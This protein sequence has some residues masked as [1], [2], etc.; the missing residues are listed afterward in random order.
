M[1]SGRLRW[2]TRIL[3]DTALI[4]LGYWLA[5]LLRFHGHLPAVNFAAFEHVLPY[6][7][8]L[9]MFV[10][11]VYEPYLYGWQPFGDIFVTILLAVTLLN[12]GTMALTFWSRGFA[13]PR[14]VFLIAP[15]LQVAL[16]CLWRWL[17]RTLTVSSEGV[18]KLVVIGEENPVQFAAR[19]QESSDRPM[20]I[21]GAFRDGHDL[22]QIKEALS[23]ADLVF[24]TT[25]DLS[26]R[27]GEIMSWCVAH[28]K[29]VLLVPSSYEVMIQG[30]R[31]T[32]LGDQLLFR[33]E[34][35]ALSPAQRFAKR[36][37][38]LLLGSLLAAAALVATPFIALA[39]KLTSP[40]PVF[41]RQ[42]RVGR[43][44]KRFF[45][46]KFRTMVDGAEK[47]TGPVLAT[48]DDPRITPVGRILRATRL[49]EI[50]QVINILKGEMSFVGPRPERPEF[51]EQF[52]QQTPDYAYRLKVKPGVTGLAQVRGRYDTSVTNKLR[53]DLHYIRN[54]SLLQDLR[55]LFQTVW[56]ALRP[57]A[58]SGLKSRVGLDLG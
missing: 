24:F 21:I 18:K 51:V 43:D 46:Y 25:S 22:A 35:L 50:P 5:Y 38:D 26:E 31:K 4:E 12:A 36:V 13:F 48:E 44:G 54:Y 56:V 55:I 30:A 27:R 9:A 3:I 16:L 6:T 41:Y 40:G 34:P 47:L 42:E 10:L 39:I 17:E 37:E 28:D 58:A 29:T 32:R 23:Q 15:F 2:L 57:R 1:K 14:T 7:T 33:I 19:F 49:D 8:L 20:D 45:I 53:Y 11:W 52:L